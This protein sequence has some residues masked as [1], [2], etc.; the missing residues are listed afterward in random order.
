MVETV[1]VRDFFDP[2][3]ESLEELGR[4]GFRM[5]QRRDGFRFGEDTVFLAHFCASVAP[6]TGKC[7][8]VLE[9]GAG[10]GAAS[11]LLSA[12]RPDLRIDAVEID[13]VSF[14]VFSR[15][16]LLNGLEERIFPILGDIRKYPDSV[17]IKIS[18]YDFVFFNAPYRK[19]ERGPMTRIEANSE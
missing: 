14:G 1:Q 13:P 18:G 12:R 19:P 9:L 2:E 16:I 15:N 10:C 7:K 3:E 4:K 6:R 8:K 17:R 5:I 11:L